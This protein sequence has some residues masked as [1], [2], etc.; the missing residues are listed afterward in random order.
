MF[1]YRGADGRIKSFGD[2]DGADWALGPGETIERLAG[3]AADYAGRFAL[4]VDRAR[5]LADGIDEAR[6]TLT[7]TLKPPPASLE[8]AIN[9]EVFAVTIE[10]GVGRL[11]VIAETPGP[12]TIEPADR[13]AFA[14]AGAGTV[15][16]EAVEAS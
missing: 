12:I 5:I 6:V 11:A 13:V 15:S 16:V 3:D 1:I 9:G 14:A 2:G 10:S 7:T 8:V 4:S